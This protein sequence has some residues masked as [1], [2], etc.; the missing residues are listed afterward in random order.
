[1][2]SVA[3]PWLIAELGVGV[4]TE[5]PLMVTQ[6]TQVS[7]PWFPGLVTVTL[8][9]CE[10]AVGLTVAV[11]VM[12]LALLT[13]TLGLVNAGGSVT[14]LCGGAPG[15]IDAFTNPVPLIV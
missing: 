8:T 12:L 6:P 11:T 7:V 2:V 9:A 1:M 10:L 3:V 14:V 4:P 13:V 15:V 5:V